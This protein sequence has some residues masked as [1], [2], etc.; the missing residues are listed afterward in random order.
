MAMGMGLVCTPFS[1][2]LGGLLGILW[3]DPISAFLSSPSDGLQ[4]FRN[5]GDF[6]VNGMQAM[7]L[8]SLRLPI[9]YGQVEIQVRGSAGGLTLFKKLDKKFFEGIL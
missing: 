5:R 4:R 9:K 1:P 7:P 8:I 2:P 6:R 3:R